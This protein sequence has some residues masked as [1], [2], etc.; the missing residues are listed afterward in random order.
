MAV[1]LEGSIQRYLGLSTD[2]KPVGDFANGEIIP[3]GSSFMETDT[4]RIYR[5]NGEG[6]RFAEPADETA[7]LLTIIYLELQ[8]IR[9]AVELTVTA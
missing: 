4:G 5:Y 6:W 1:K 8:A 2:D 3:A 9:A 7:M